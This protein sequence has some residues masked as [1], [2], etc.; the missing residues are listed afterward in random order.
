MTNLQRRNKL[1][2][3]IM[4]PGLELHTHH[5]G[6]Y[7]SAPGRGMGGVR[8]QDIWLKGE[9]LKSRMPCEY[10]GQSLAGLA[11]GRCMGLNTCCVKQDRGGVARS[12]LCSSH[13][14]LCFRLVAVAL[15]L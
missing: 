3:G 4:D 2:I 1:A 11:Y 13:K 5:D 15:R 12:H 10:N 7:M 9:P 14:A 8:T 6:W